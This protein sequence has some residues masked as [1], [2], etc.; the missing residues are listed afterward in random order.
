M[1]DGRRP[2]TLRTTAR[3][4]AGLDD[5]GAGDITFAEDG[6]REG[7]LA[8]TGA[9]A[10]VGGGCASPEVTSFSIRSCR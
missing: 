7:D 1:T 4:L 8:R 6:R 9:S 10:A 5:A 3:R 2:E